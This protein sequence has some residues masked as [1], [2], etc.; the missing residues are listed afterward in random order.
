MIRRSSKI[1]QIRPD[2]LR[3]MSLMYEDD[4]SPTRNQSVW[5]MIESFDRIGLS[6]VYQNAYQTADDF[7]MRLSA[8]NPL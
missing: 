6:N 1:A 3:T 5:E 2:L 4:G 8:I 7:F